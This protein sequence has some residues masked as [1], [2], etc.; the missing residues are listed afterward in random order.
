MK[1]VYAGPFI[2]LKN[3]FFLSK[4]ETSECSWKFVWWHVLSD[5]TRC[6]VEIAFVPLHWQILSPPMNKNSLNMFFSSILIVLYCKDFSQSTWVYWETNAS[7]TPLTV[8][9]FAFRLP[10]VKKKS[11][12]FTRS[13]DKHQQ[14]F[15]NNWSFPLPFACPV[16]H[17]KRS[18]APS[19]R[20]PPGVRKP[21]LIHSCNLSSRNW[22]RRAVFQSGFNEMF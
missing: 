2:S 20:Q 8:K 13:A 18:C 5:G 4:L 12:L 1:T 15:T 21:T 17:G 16:S 9:S 3:G 10:E 11:S 22:L 19:T 7:N 14:G 6:R